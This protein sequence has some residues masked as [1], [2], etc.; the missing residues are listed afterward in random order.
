MKNG[1]DIKVAY[2]K[3]T[4][5]ITLYTEQLKHITNEEIERQINRILNT[6]EK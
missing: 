5:I 3:A 4:E 2:K 1:T 6:L